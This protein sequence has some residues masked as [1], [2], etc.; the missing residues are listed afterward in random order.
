MPT[1]L[2]PRSLDSVRGTCPHRVHVGR[3][4][5]SVDA[6]TGL[7]D[8][9]TEGQAAALADAHGVDRA[10]ISP[11]GAQGE[12]DDSGNSEPEDE[13]EPSIAARDDATHR[14]N[15]DGEPLC[16]GTTADDEP[17]TRTVNKLGGY[18]YQHKED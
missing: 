4:R 1:V 5:F 11:D 2:H 18:C 9:D 13:S 8:L 14:T 17:C 12:S 7:V 6:E 16:A 3:V 10:A 15:A